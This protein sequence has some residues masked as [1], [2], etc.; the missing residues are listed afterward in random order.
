MT[1]RAAGGILAGLTLVACIT[2]CSS[3]GAGSSVAIV[4]SAPTADAAGLV[5]AQ[6]PQCD[7]GA[8]ILDYLATGDNGGDPSVDQV[9]AS[10]VGVPAP[11]ARALADQYIESCD[12]QAAQQKAAA[13]SSAA[14]ASA[15]ESASAASAAASAS[16][17]Q[18][19]AA[20]AAQ[21]QRSCAAIG[22]Q[23][24][25]SLCQSASQGSAANDPYY[26]CSAVYVE[27]TDE[28]TIDQTSLHN[29]STDHPGC[30]G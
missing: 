15:R 24:G 12:Q 21:R 29:V 5:V 20:V 28:G 26:P 27:F 7:V 16:Q 9:F 6:Y 13:S 19:D 8:E 11:Q 10:H 2:G 4:A 22:G 18:H 17:A 30:F 3:R 1:P 25:D 23:A 14:E